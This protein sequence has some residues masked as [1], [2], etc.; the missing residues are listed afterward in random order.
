MGREEDVSVIAEALASVH[1]ASYRFIDVPALVKD[2]R[3]PDLLIL[4]YRAE[5]STE[6]A[7]ADLRQQPRLAELPRLAYYPAYLFRPGGIRETP[8]VLRL[9][10]D[11]PVLLSRTAELLAIER[12]RKFRTLL[13]VVRRDGQTVMVR[14]EDFSPA[15][16]SFLSE[17]PLR[18]HE[19]IQIQFFLPDMGGRVALKGSI[20]RADGPSSGGSGLFGVRFVGVA[21]E[22]VE[23]M[24]EFID[25]GTGT[26]PA[27]IAAARVRQE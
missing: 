21:D 23:R 14:S 3:Q 7:L 4:A 24:K 5:A 8:D 27:G 13:T 25:R 11:V 17:A 20:V 9:P 2:G 10:V 26:P 19:E 22:V 18:L 15:G 1:A 6:R 12:R 16:M